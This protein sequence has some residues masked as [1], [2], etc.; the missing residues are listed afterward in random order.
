[1]KHLLLAAFA[2]VATCFAAKSAFADET[3]IDGITWT[4][5]VANEQA[6]I[7]GVA[8]I[9]SSCDLVVPSQV[10]G[11]TVTAIGDSVCQHNG[12]VTSLTIPDS[13]QSIGYMSFYNCYSLQSLEIGAELE[14]LGE[15]V[16]DSC[17]QLATI[18]VA[19]GNAAFTAENNILYDKGKTRFVL[20]PRTVTEVE[21]PAAV[22]EIDAALLQQ[23]RGL[24]SL[25]VAAGNATYSAQDNVLYNADKTLLII[26]PSSLTGTFEIPAT[27]TEIGADAFSGSDVSAVVF[28]SALRKIGDSAFCSCDSLE[29]IELPADLDTIGVGAFQSCN[30]LRGADLGGVKDIGASAFEWCNS[31]TAIVIPN[32]TTNIGGMAFFDCEH[33]FDV[34]IGSAVAKIGKGA[35]QDGP[36]EEEGYMNTVVE[37]AFGGCSSLMDFKVAADNATFEEIGGCI[38]LK[39]D[40]YAAKTLIAYPAGRDDLYFEADDVVSDYNVTKIWDGACAYCYNFTELYITNSVREIGAQSFTCDGNLSKLVIPDGP[41]NIC[42]GAFQLNLE[43]MDVEIAGTVKRIGEAVFV[44]DYMPG[45]IWENPRLGRLVLHEGIEEI[46]EAAFDF[47]PY[48]GKIVVPDSVT[49]L[50]ENAFAEDSSCPQIVVGDG[51]ETISVGAFSSCGECSRLTIGAN[52]TSIEDYAFEG[53]EALTELEIPD[54]VTEIGSSAFKDCWSLKTLSLP[55]SLVTIG[56]NA[57]SGC[58]SLRRLVVPL[59]VTTIEEGAF[60]YG[61]GLEK[62]YLPLSLK[63]ESDEDTLAFIASVFTDC[64]FESLEAEDLAEIFVWYSDK[65]ALNYVTVTYADDKGGTTQVQVLDFIDKLPTPSA[66]GFAFAGWWTTAEDTQ[67]EQG[68]PVSI[69]DRL[70]ANATFYARWAATPFVSGGDAPWLAAYYDDSSDQWVWR[71]GDIVAGET[72]TATMSVTGPC[73]LSYEYLNDGD[74][75]TDFLRVYIDGD[76]AAEYDSGGWES[77]AIEIVAAGSHTVTWSFEKMSNSESAVAQLAAISVEAATPHTVTFNLTGGTMSDATTRNVLRSVGKLPRPR[78]ASSIFG[79]WWTT[80]DDS[81][82]R[83]NDGDEVTGDLALYAHWVSAP[84]TAG[85][86]KDWFID[87]EGNYQSES[88]VYGEQIYAEVS[89]TGPC[90][91][92]FDWKAATS[93]WTNNQFEFFVDGEYMSGLQATSRGT[94]YW[95]SESFDIEGEGEHVI[96]WVFEYDDPD[97]SYYPMENCVWLRNVAVGSVSAVTFDPNYEG[98]VSDTQMLLGVLGELPVPDRDDYFAFVGWFT[99][100]EGGEKVTPDTPVTGAVTYYA[101]WKP[102][103]FKFTGEWREDEDGS[104]RT[105]STDTYT[106]CYAFKEVEGPCTV[107]FKW[108]AQASEYNTVNIYDIVGGGYT[109]VTNV[110]NVWMGDW[111]ETTLTIADGSTHTIRFQ[112]YTG[113]IA[114]E[115]YYLAIKDFTVTPLASYTLTFDPNYGGAEATTRKVIQ[116]GAVVG[117]PPSVSRSGYAVDGWWTEPTGGER[118]TATTEV[119]ADTTYYAH[120]VECPFTFEGYPWEMGPDGEWRTARMDTY[121]SNYGATITVQGPCVVTFDWKK[122][123]GS[124]GRYMWLK[125]D[126]EYNSKC[127]STEWETKS[128]TFTEEGEHTIF[129]NAYVNNASYATT[130]NNCYMVRNIQ[131]AELVPCVVTF[132]ANYTGAPEAT[133]Q[134]Y[135]A[136]DALGTTPSVARSGYALVGWFTAAIGGEQVTAETVVNANMTVYAHW[137]EAVSFDSTGGDANWTVEADGSWKSGVITHSQSTW[138]QVT[139]TGPCDVSFKWKTSSESGYDWLTFYVDDVQSGRI[140]GDN[141]WAE[142]SLTFES[143]SHVLKWT[144]S[145]DGS[146]SSGSDCGWVKDFQAISPE[147]PAPEANVDTEKLPEGTADKLNSLDVVVSDETG[148]RTIAVKEGETLTQEEVAAIADSIVIETTIAGT[149]EKADTSD[150]YAVNYDTTSNAIVITL[151]QPEMDSTV[152]DEKKE[153]GDSTGMLA[154]VGEGGVELSTEEP[155]P[156]EEDVTN[157][158]TEVS[159]LPV[160][161]VRGLYYQASWGTSLEGM[162]QGQKVQATGS[163]LNLGV[164]KQTGSFGFYKVTVSEK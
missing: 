14:S 78:K 106:S 35:E 148:V 3:E 65:S 6:T 97:G 96:R 53:C 23:F 86:D 110:N 60:A 92:S 164:I 141:D 158:N 66:S 157:G 5:T 39:A 152:E 49:T 26:A 57:F 72:S 77:D 131:V 142:K 122:D 127:E 9:P 43:L 13:I 103:P 7:T 112:F 47:C 71:S 107:S 108:K 76:L 82:T 149:S 50:A 147:P 146:A 153:D 73:V 48:L 115:S 10:D 119:S 123:V 125:L 37:P 135:V 116:D 87:E 101:H 34:T 17:R 128:V 80:S 16:F 56:T 124:D 84:F 94:P 51:I 29:A 15:R 163:E 54:G 70:T 40:P 138:A 111:E 41:T 33:L 137:K 145:K 46:A 31:L 45:D 160:K 114:G 120:W 130:E 140:S 55:D 132:D 12:R 117:Y 19:A 83:V 25:T 143:G 8:N 44:H 126:G 109:I 151:K 98:G 121:S 134:N 67:E 24:T 102:S 79:G 85:G 36:D 20:V 38:F 154:E 133:T 144:Y 18:T 58:S 69:D 104:W 59:G 91:V 95:D 74:D 139:V 21:I 162:T 136:G 42:F 52:V 64:G 105:A 4:Y 61:Y 63:P 118:I 68:E 75:G 11:I 81:G 93:Y 88:L 22:T 62:I 32:T 155:T 113:W 2:A 129:F 150:G 89:Y 100:P 1:M 161:A 90:R 99:L 159:A 156:S 28:P 27:V 30:G